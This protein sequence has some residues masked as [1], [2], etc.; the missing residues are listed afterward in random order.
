MARNGYNEATDRGN[1]IGEK[2][3]FSYSRLAPGNPDKL[4]SRDTQFHP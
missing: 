1:P 4:S 2:D 3:I